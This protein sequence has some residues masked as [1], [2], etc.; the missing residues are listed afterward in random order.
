MLAKNFF[1]L[2]LFW[3]MLDLAMASEPIT[4]DGSFQEVDLSG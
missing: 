2:A 4:C 1:S 3:G